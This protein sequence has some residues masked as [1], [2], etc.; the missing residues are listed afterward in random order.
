MTRVSR[1]LKTE[2]LN[3]EPIGEVHFEALARLRSDPQIM[4]AMRGGAESRARTRA[5]LDWYLA[6]WEEQGY[7]MWAVLDRPG[8]DFLGECGFWLRDDGQGVSLRFVLKRAVQGRGLAREAAAAALGY[9]FEGAEIDRI[10]AVAQDDN[11]ASHRVLKSIGMTPS[12]QLPGI[13]TGLTVYRL[14]RLDWIAANRVVGK[15]ENESG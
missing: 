1:I 15:R 3:L 4:A 8:G 11:E 6:T 9:G 7:G 10:V 14:T 5:T 12:H 2:R 13:E